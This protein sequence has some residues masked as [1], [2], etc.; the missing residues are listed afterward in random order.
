MR[1]LPTRVLQYGRAIVR[2]HPQMIVW[3]FRR[4]FRS[5]SMPLLGGLYERQVSAHQATIPQVNLGDAGLLA[6]ARRVRDF[7]APSHSATTWGIARGQVS[8]FGRTVDFGSIAGIDWMHQIDGGAHQLWRQKLSYFGFAIDLLSAGG[9]DGAATVIA[10]IDAFEAAVHWRDPGALKDPW[11]SYSAANRILNLTAGL[12]LHTAAGGERQPAIEAFIAKN[13]ALLERN[14]EYELNYNHLE[15]NWA[16][17]CLYY[18]GQTAL[19]PRRVALLER[20][21]RNIIDL[22]LTRDGM[23]SERSPMY[24][25]L[26]ILSLEMFASCNALSDGLRRHAANMHGAAVAVSAALVHM[27]GDI[28][29]FNDCWR[30]E[31]P[32]PRDVLDI[33]APEGRTVLADAGYVRLAGAAT[34]LIF[35]AGPIGPRANP[36]HGHSDF[37]SFELSREGRRLV[38]D[39][40]T[41]NYSDTPDRRYERSAA[42]HNGPVFVGIEP[43]EYFGS[44]R[45]GKLAHAEL[46]AAPAGD[47]L[48]ACGRLELDPDRRVGRAI[49][50][51]P[52]RGAHVVDRW[53]GDGQSQ[54]RLLS[55][56]PM[57]LAPNGMRAV[58]EDA[59]FAIVV[60]VGRLISVKETSA[61][62]EYLTPKPAVEILLAPDA[63]GLLRFDIEFDQGPVDST[64]VFGPMDRCLCDALG[65]VSR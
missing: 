4:L 20:G 63:E 22:T 38:I 7:Y 48:I 37:L 56:L 9:A 43:V 41:E 17:L 11:G 19:D 16:A 39:P 59:T 29:V 15:R 62:Q 1:G 34:A 65:L 32:R 3:Q 61:S 57:R 25:M 24:H 47:E 36:A 30:G 40:G 28:A 33:D 51:D 54:T 23:Q 55:P 53:V 13:V 64:E 35:D 10:L 8:Y 60:V 18:T 49:W 2:M 44:F 50:L 58:S 52:T 21:V 46:L 27:D 5:K 26:T 6:G 14:L 45:I 31:V 12:A 42:A